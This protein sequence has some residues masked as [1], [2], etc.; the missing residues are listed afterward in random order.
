MMKVNNTRINLELND[1]ASLQTSPSLEVQEKLNGSIELNPKIVRRPD[2]FAS[3][4]V[5]ASAS[6]NTLLAAVS[7]KSFVICGYSFSVI[8]DAS[9][10]AATSAIGL[11]FTRN[12]STTNLLFEMQLLTLTAQEAFI[13]VELVRPIKVDENTA[14]ILAQPTFTVGNM[15]RSMTVHGYYE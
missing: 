11:R 4:A 5:T 12:G 8:K 7:G 6:T 14:L 15:A 2:V 3:L 1:A 13:A 9:C 10:D